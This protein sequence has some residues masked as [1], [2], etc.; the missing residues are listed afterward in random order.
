[1]NIQ[2]GKAAQQP[3]VPN[4]TGQKLKDAK[5]ALQDAA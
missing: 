4:L 3:T 1:V 2:V 5:Q